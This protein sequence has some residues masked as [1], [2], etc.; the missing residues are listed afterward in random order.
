MED[1]SMFQRPRTVALEDE[2]P[3]LMEGVDLPT[4]PIGRVWLRGLHAKHL[5]LGISGVY[6]DTK[7]VSEGFDS[8]SPSLSQKTRKPYHIKTHKI[9][10]TNNTA[11]EEKTRIGLEETPKKK[12]RLH[13]EESSEFRVQNRFLIAFPHVLPHSK[14]EI[15]VYIDI[16]N[17]AVFGNEN[18]HCFLGLVKTREMMAKKDISKGKNPTMR[19]P[20]SRRDSDSDSEATES[21]MVAESEPVIRTQ[22]SVAEPESDPLEDVPIARA[23]KKRKTQEGRPK[24][25]NINE[26][27]GAVHTEGG[28]VSEATRMF[29][30]FDTV[31]LGRDESDNVAVEGPGVVPSEPPHEAIEPIHSDQPPKSSDVAVDVPPLA[32]EDIQGATDLEP[33]TVV[34]PLQSEQ[35]P[36]PGRTSEEITEVEPEPN[37]M[38]M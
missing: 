32:E 3:G 30:S 2:N 22:Q 5:Y 38:N 26:R 13:C 31:S 15:R 7:T 18:V 1:L 17:V 4:R 28:S 33:L 10:T 12:R 37:T 6:G 23:F 16:E 9:K 34:M 36:E 14:D 21:N 25:T 11:T 35:Q 19:V 27:E 29:D 20:P 8:V 24:K